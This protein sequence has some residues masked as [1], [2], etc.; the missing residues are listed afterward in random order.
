ML[1]FLNLDPDFS[2]LIQPQI[3]MFPYSAFFYNFGYEMTIHQ[4]NN[5]IQDMV[6]LIFR[7]GSEHDNEEIIRVEFCRNHEKKLSR[8][9]RSYICV[10]IYICI[11][12]YITL[13]SE[14]S[15]S[16]IEKIKCHEKV[17]QRSK[18]RSNITEWQ[19]FSKVIDLNDRKI[20]PKSWKNKIW[21][22]IFLDQVTGGGEGVWE[23]CD[24]G[25]VSG[26]S[27]SYSRVSKGR[28]QNLLIAKILIMPS[29]RSTSS[30]EDINLNLSDQLKWFLM[31][32]I[33]PNYQ[34]WIQKLYIGQI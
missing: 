33:T 1:D 22:K 8:F 15:I 27:K 12:M 5:N 11:H 18:L 16:E 7:D 9:Q 31:S 17:I 14:K 32:K 20:Y 30:F 34:K 29:R 3:W 28:K 19:P 23:G 26:G 24:W 2:F 21:P 6:I 10:Y 4:S 13:N 25:R